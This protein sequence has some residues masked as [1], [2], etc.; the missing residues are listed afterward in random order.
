MRFEPREAAEAVNYSKENPIREAV[1][2]LAGLALVGGV[3]FF[4]FGWVAEFAIARTPP[5]W[6]ARLFGAFW[7]EAD[8]EDDSGVQRLVDR[9]QR[10]W[11]DNPYAIRVQVADSPDVNAFALPGGLVMVTRGLLDQVESE[12]EL[13]FVLGHELGHFRHRDHLR[14]VGRE[15]ASQLAVSVVTGAVGA[16]V[17]SLQMLR[18]VATRSFGRAQES[19]ADRFALELVFRE[20]GHL[21][22]ATDFFE[23]LPDSGSALAREAARFLSTHPVSEDRV[24]ELA[25]FGRERGWP[26]EGRLVPL[27]G[28]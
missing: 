4:S 1:I 20:Y 16:S 11:P 28:R 8:G 25:E 15:L 7:D 27:K 3:T 23:R 21:G 2:L 19:E 17:D 9:L 13:A 5:S 6:E 18:T 22:G 24:E 26:A 10:H 14:I 12:N